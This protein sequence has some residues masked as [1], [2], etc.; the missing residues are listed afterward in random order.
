[1]AAK[2]SFV[3]VGANLAGGSAAETLRKEGF[4]GR[5]TLLGQEPDRPYDRPPLSKEYLR[6]EKEEEKLFFK[7]EGFY[8]E[9]DIDLHLGVKA[10]R[11]DPTEQIIGLETGE[12][13]K[14]D[15]LLL[16]TG[17]RVLTLN[18]P[19]IDLDGVYYLRTLSDSRRL[20]EAIGRS[21]KAV[22][23]GAG[24]IGSEVA[25][26][27]RMKGLEVT[28]LETAAVPLSMA[29]GEELGAIYA[30]IHRSHGIDLRLREGLQE[31]QGHGRVERVVTSSGAAIDCDLV[32][33][34]VGI[35]PETEIAEGTEIA[36]D[37][38][39]VVDEFCQT[40]IPGI[41]AAGDVAN[42]WH[43]ALGRHLRVEHWDH[44]LNQGAAAARNMLGQRE[45]YSPVLYFWSDQYDLNLQYVGH[46]SQW[47]H[48]V[49]R[50]DI[51]EQRFTAF[52]MN[53]GLVLAAL[54]INRF[55]DLNPA[56][57]LIGQRIRVE[58]KLLADEDVN[59]KSLVA[60]S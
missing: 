54:A 51:K 36:I 47:D 3:I 52:F 56:R 15:K 30:K 32:A 5:I 49:Y 57:K 60:P 41:F 46:A 14:Y 17:G 31:I 37:N 26:S 44:A 58:E 39:V 45:A 20:A 4:D 27:C 34:G 23:V 55:K 7:P 1:M 35:A 59:L 6:G 21:R 12:A 8:Q 18:I 38:G 43:P 24:F 13:L 42:W 22:I 33:I 29:L 19:G 9:Q 50:G 16:A 25:A 11:L 28:V 2:Q 48:V 10:I 53:D 40:N